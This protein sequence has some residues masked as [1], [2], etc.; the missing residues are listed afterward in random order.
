MN[1]VRQQTMSLEKQ[2]NRACV[3]FDRYISISMC[4]IKQRD[5]KYI[6]NKSKF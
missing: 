2:G 1:K 5:A 6:E 3:D 4:K